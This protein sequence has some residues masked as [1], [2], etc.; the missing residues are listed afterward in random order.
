MDQNQSH[1]QNSENSHVFHL[2]KK[3]LSF[4]GNLLDIF[5]FFAFCRNALPCIP[6]LIHTLP[7]HCFLFAF[8]CPICVNCFFKVFYWWMNLDSVQWLIVLSINRLPPKLHDRHEVLCVYPF[9][10]RIILCIY[11]KTYTTSSII[12][13][14][15]KEH[16][17]SFL[18][19]SPKTRS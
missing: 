8:I 17:G 7:S 16:F 15:L 14:V 19:L 5:F 13:W 2:N 18:F 10:I 11:S 4:Y 9:N 1:Q 3:I 12:F 6:Y